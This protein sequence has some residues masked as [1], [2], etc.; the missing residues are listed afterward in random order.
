[1]FMILV[2]GEQDVTPNAPNKEL[3]HSAR[4]LHHADMQSEARNQ[5][6]REDQELVAKGSP[7]VPPEHVSGGHH[8]G[9]DAHNTVQPGRSGGERLCPGNILH[10]LTTTT[11]RK[12]LEGQGDWG[13]CAC[14]RCRQGGR[15][16]VWS[17]QGC[18][19]SRLHCL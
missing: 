4:D 13:C 16:S 3:S 9:K 8:V 5:G 12:R 11:C 19:R 18:S 2:I 10:S 1:M 6:E 14:I 17:P 7:E 15:R